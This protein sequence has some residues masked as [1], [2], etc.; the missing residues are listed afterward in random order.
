MT[1]SWVAHEN[2]PATHLSVDP[3]SIELVGKLCV[4][5]VGRDEK[6]RFWDGLLA[7]SWIGRC[8]NLLVLL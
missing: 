2:V 7:V 4:V 5:S 8:C 3:W 1:N 6:M